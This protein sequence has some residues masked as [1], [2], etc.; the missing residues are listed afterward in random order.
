MKVSKYL[1]WATAAATILLS[2]ALCWQCIDIYIQGS[3]PENAAL[4]ENL[5]EPVF[6]MDDVALRLSVLKWPFFAYVILLVVSALIRTEGSVAEKKAIL[7][8]HPNK[9]VPQ[10]K[11]TERNIVSIRIA[12][13]I[14][15]AAFI[16]WGI[17]NG[18]LRDVLVKAIN[19][20]TECIGLG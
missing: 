6:K 1:R 13:Y 10:A 16:I 3:S 9:S 12:M 2:I 7:C 17:L 5:L 18:G 14:A 19:I 8:Q 4:K 20:C 15:A 11:K